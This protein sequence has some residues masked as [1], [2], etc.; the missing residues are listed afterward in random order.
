LALHRPVQYI[1]TSVFLLRRTDYMLSDNNKN[2]VAVYVCASVEG[3]ENSRT[4]G[5]RT[6]G[7][8][9]VPTIAMRIFSHSNVDIAHN[10][11]NT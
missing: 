9:T 1:I 4:L 7:A 10:P 3:Q 6:D 2:M 11:L 5:F 8:L